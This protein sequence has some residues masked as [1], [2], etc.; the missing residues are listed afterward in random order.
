MLANLPGA[1]VFAEGRDEEFGM[2]PKG[3]H[4]RGQAGIFRD[5]LTREGRSQLSEEPGA[6]KASATD[7]DSGAPGLIHHRQGIPSA[8]DVTIAKHGEAIQCL[9]EVSDRRPICAAGIHLRRRAPM[10]R[11]PRDTRIPGHAA[12]LQIGEVVVID[13]FAHLHGDGHATTRGSHRGRHNVGK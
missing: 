3:G 10:Q 12:G 8:E 4:D 6:P 2:P 9:H 7:D 5:R 1:G 11:D 13:P